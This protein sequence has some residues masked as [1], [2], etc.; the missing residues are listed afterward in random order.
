M[1]SD[2]DPSAAPA[3]PSVAQQT[4]SPPHPFA[5]I[6]IAVASPLAMLAPPRR[7]DLKFFSL[8]A[9]FSLS[10]D[11]ITRHY[12]GQGIWARTWGRVL[13]SGELP[14]KAEESKRRLEAEKLARMTGEQRQAYMVEKAKQRSWWSAPEGDDWAQKRAEKDLDRTKKGDSVI[15]GYIKDA[16]GTSGDR[17][18]VEEQGKGTK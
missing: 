8:T 16:L 18:G 6:L 11:Q 7:R 5:W 9:C 3:P 1:S 2:P 14:A 10:T 15:G 13:P 17:N 12:T 4:A